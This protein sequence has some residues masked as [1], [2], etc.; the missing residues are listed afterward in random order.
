MNRKFLVCFCIFLLVRDLVLQT[1]PTRSLHI[2]Q[3][4]EAAVTAAKN[5]R[6]E[7]E[8]DKYVKDLV[9]EE[10]DIRS[11]W[12]KALV[13][14]TFEE[15]MELINQDLRQVWVKLTWVYQKFAVDR[16]ETHEFFNQLTDLVSGARMLVAEQPKFTWNPRDE[17]MFAADSPTQKE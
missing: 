6:F 9:H 13:P 2:M 11:G 10:N 12:Q 16:S 15:A 7:K 8:L 17:S 3:S 1:S 14:T 4:T 5:A